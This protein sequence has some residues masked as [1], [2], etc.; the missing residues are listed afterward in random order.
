MLID[1]A[2]MRKRGRINENVERYSVSRSLNA[3]DRAD[4]CLIMIDAAEG[5]TEQDTKIAGYVHEA[6]KASIVVVNKWDLVEKETNTMKNFK[7]KVK[8]GFNFMMY[9]RL[10]LFRQLQVRGWDSLFEMMDKVVEQNTKR[11][12]TGILNDVLGEAV[13]AVQPPSDKGK[14]LKIYYTTQA[15][16]KPPTFVLFV[17]DAK[18]AHYSY[19][20]YIENQFR[21]R[22]GFEG[23]P[24]KFIIREKGKKK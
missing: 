12:S 24:I 6:G 20:R 5:I 9:A 15:D 22:F 3:I 2:G 21:A 13:S 17:N 8:E 23:T 19:V 18:L 4:V 10:C 14:R 7:I 1:T 16:I 11:I